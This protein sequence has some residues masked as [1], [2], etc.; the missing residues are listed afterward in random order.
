M[1][2]VDVSVI[3]EVEVIALF[4]IPSGPS[5]KIINRSLK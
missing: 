4:K 2:D 3:E 1:P 5:L